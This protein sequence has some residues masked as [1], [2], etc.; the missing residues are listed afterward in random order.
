[1]MGGRES[2]AWRVALEGEWVKSA[3]VAFGCYH[4]LS[5]PEDMDDV[6]C[7]LMNDAQRTLVLI[8]SPFPATLTAVLILMLRQI[9]G[10]E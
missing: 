7:N 10:A 8:R 1:M 5:F 9:D 4:M 3:G 2:V 6:R